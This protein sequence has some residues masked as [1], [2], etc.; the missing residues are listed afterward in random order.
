MEGR[1]AYA[2]QEPWIF[3]S[4]LR[5]NILFGKPYEPDW[6]STVVDVCAL[7]KVGEI[8]ILK[9]LEYFISFSKQY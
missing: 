7:E 4:S 2:A 8:A 3:S 6:Y 5:D 1:V 9:A